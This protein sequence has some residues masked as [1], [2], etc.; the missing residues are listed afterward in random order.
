MNT[1][2]AYDRRHA[3]RSSGSFSK[4]YKPNR[5][6]RIRPAKVCFVFRPVRFGVKPEITVS[7]SRPEAP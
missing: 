4:S 3:P 7:D 1:S 2:I 6:I 5:V